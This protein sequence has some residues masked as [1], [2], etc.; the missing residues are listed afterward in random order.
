[1]GSN[2]N[3]NNATITSFSITFANAAVASGAVVIGPGGTTTPKKNTVFT[4]VGKTLYVSSF[5]PLKPDGSQ[6]VFTITLGDCGDNIAI[7]GAVAST[8][9]GALPGGSGLPFVPDATASAALGA[10]YAV[11]CGNI[12]CGDSNKS[13][14]SST[15]VATVTRGFY[16]VD[17]VSTIGT[18]LCATVPY[19]VSTIVGTSKRHFAWPISGA[20]SDPAATFQYTFNNDALTLVAWFNTDGSP[21][22]SPGTPDFITALPCNA[23]SNFLPAPYGTITVAVGATD[24]TIMV[25]TTTPPGGVATPTTPFDIV[26]GTEGALERMTV[27]GM[28]GPAN[29]QTWTVTRGVAPNVG[30]IAPHA[31]PLLAMSTPLPIMTSTQG[32]VG[33]YVTGNQA[34]MCIEAQGSGITTFLDIGDAWNTQP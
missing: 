12:A 4:A 9:D 10:T 24:T 18:N 19:T 31:L 32:V 22:S 6:L 25:D 23:N 16:D 15:Y 34:Q 27:T 5:Y 17:G 30:P 28:S 8:S 13:V 2:A 1:M 21:A 11:A 7:T 20:T 29:A 33:E 3:N 26:I 14:P